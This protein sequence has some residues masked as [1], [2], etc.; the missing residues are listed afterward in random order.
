MINNYLKIAF[1]NLWKNKTFSVINVIGLA[2]GIT[3]GLGMF[4]IVRHEFNYDNFHPGNKQ[5]YRIVSQFKYP[6]GIE[7]SSGIPLALP[8]SFSL[9]FPQIK[10]VATIFGGY[11][12]QLDIA[13]ED[14]QQNQKRF[15]IETGVFYC[16]PVFFDVF[17]F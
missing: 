17:N 10:K 9:D 4:I 6:E 7:Y 13:D 14:L 15:K 2:L 12:N 1:R 3:C 8:L 11:N 16:N 5:I